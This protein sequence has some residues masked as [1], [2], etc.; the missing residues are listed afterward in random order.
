MLEPF[1]SS[2]ASI[3]HNGISCGGR[4]ETQDRFALRFLVSSAPRGDSCARALQAGPRSFELLPTGGRGPHLFAEGV[5]STPGDEAGG[6]FSPDGNEFYF[7]RLNPTTTFSADRVAVRFA[8]E[9]REMERAGSAAVFRQE[10]GFSAA[11]FCR[12]ERRCTSG[13]RGLRRIPRR[14]CL[15]IWKVERTA[16]GLGRTACLCPRRSMRRTD[17]WNWGASVTGDG[18]MYFTSDRDEPGRPQIYRSRLV[19][20]RVSDTGETGAGNQFGVQRLRSVRERR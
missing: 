7:A 14:M 17:R 6:V 18:T 3:E 8:L 16:D 9:R 13:R 11:T 20:W 12:T 19:S 1:S 2:R 10:S 4:H 15:R 5:I